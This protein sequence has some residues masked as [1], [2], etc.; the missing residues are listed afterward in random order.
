ML[1]A[2]SARQLSIQSFCLA[3]RYPQALTQAKLTFGF[4]PVSEIVELGHPVKECEVIVEIEDIT[5]ADDHHVQRGVHQTVGFIERLPILLSLRFGDIGRR[6]QSASDFADGLNQVSEQCEPYHFCLQS[7]I[8]SLA[9]CGNACN[10]IRSDA[11]A[12][13]KRPF[14]SR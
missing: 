6:F 3:H 12:C 7:S 10:L 14:R 2:D 8:F 13:R 1:C 5:E 4:V 9:L 11:S